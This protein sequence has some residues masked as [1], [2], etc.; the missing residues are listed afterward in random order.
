MPDSVSFGTTDVIVVLSDYESRVIDR[1]RA[2][3]S[4]GIIAL[5]TPYPHLDT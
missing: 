3:P 4:T 5:S 1:G 2:T